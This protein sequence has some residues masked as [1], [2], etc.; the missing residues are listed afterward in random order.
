MTGETTTT[1][2]T[3]T[4]DSGGALAS[5][6]R[7]VAH[8]RLGQK[9][10]KQQQQQQPQPV[11][12]FEDEVMSSKGVNGK[13]EKK[14]EER[15]VAVGGRD[16]DEETRDGKG[17]GAG[18]VSQPQEGQ[19]QGLSGSGDSGSSG[20]PFTSPH[21]ELELGERRRQQQ[22]RAKELFRQQQEQRAQ[23]QQ[24]QALQSSAAAASP[25]FAGV[26]GK[27]NQG[28][29]A[30]TESTKA[31]RRPSNLKA[32][33]RWKQKGGLRGVELITM[34][35]VTEGKDDERK[36]VTC[37]FVSCLTLFISISILNSSIS[38]CQWTS[39][40]SSSSTVKSRAAG[41]KATAQAVDWEIEK[42]GVCV[43]YVCVGYRVKCK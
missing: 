3:N 17:G 37:A 26:E 27:E 40:S 29:S 16:R 2:T 13:L 4:V 34:W 39:W 36:E 23:Q 38:T 24:Q 15:V 35:R 31:K 28:G 14:E 33:V 18:E 30:T 32:K 19:A 25:P 7:R 41:G 20:L 12:V 22:R 21:K 6:R 1:T 42:V 11:V 43:C 9:L 5:R 8:S 10:G